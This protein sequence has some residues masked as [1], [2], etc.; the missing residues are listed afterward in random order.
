MKARTSFR[1]L[2]GGTALSLALLVGSAQADMMSDQETAA[3]LQQEIELYP[4][5]GEYALD[6]N[7]EDGMIVVSGMI[8]KQEDYD[9]VQEIIDGMTDVDNIENRIVRD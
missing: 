1:I 5:L 4:E 8:D 2:A 7:A 3:K 9:K 6:V